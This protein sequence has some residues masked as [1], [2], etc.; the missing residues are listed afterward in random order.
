MV[1][2]AAAIRISRSCRTAGSFSVL[3]RSCKVA[4]TRAASWRNRRGRSGFRSAIF[5]S[6]PDTPSRPAPSGLYRAVTSKRSFA[7]W[8]LR[9][10][11]PGVGAGTA[12]AETASVSKPA[13]NRGKHPARERDSGFRFESSKRVLLKELA[14]TAAPHFTGPD[15]GSFVRGWRAPDLLSWAFLGLLDGFP[16]E[17][18]GTSGPGGSFLR[19]EA[20]EKRRVLR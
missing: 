3:S 16:D 14:R 5:S 20:G 10:T 17:I 11:Q 15:G 12:A 2:W 6:S 4:R 18:A 8:L 13:A 9:S 19:D 1:C 7:F